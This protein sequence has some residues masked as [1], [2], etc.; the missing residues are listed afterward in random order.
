METAKNRVEFLLPSTFLGEKCSW[1]SRSI[2]GSVATNDQTE[3]TKSRQ[4]DWQLIIFIKICAK[5][6][7]K[8]QR[9]CEFHT[10][11]W[12][13]QEET[14]TTKEEPSHYGEDGFQP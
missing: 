10:S 8:I 3:A 2:C 6:E 9:R 1:L 12:R 14:R 11:R 13:K 7:A 5:P 4:R